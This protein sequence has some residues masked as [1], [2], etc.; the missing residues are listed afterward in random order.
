MVLLLEGRAPSGALFGWGPVMDRVAIFV[1]AGYVYAQGGLITLGI[2]SRAQMDVDVSAFVNHLEGLARSMAEVPLLRT[3]WYDGAFQ[4]VATA[5]H[6]SIA[7]LP[8][9]K[10]RLGTVNAKGQQKGVD[11]LLYRDLITLSRERS[12]SDAVVVAGDADLCEGVRAAQ[13]LGVRVIVVGLDG[14]GGA[15]QARELIQEADRSQVFRDSDIRPFFS[16]KASVPA[17]ATTGTRT[18]PSS[19]WQAKTPPGPATDLVVVEEAARGYAQ[20]WLAAASSDDLA[21]LKAVDPRIPTPIDSAL[22]QA[23]EAAAGRALR[24]DQPAR[25]AVR[26]A[27]WTQVRAHIPPGA[28]AAVSPLT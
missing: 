27:F 19:V 4:R 21:S 8:D 25:H 9:V 6:H 24:Q 23:A 28:S 22:L 7:R 20:G 3:Y 14:R 5:E 11:A 15:S 17:R 18:H 13:E 1:D 26:R 12:I 2:K 16:R 10:L